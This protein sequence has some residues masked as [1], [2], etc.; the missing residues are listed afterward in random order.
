MKDEWVIDGYNLLHW[1]KNSRPASQ[2]SREKL[3]QMLANFAS[4]AGARVSVVF[5]GKG[6]NDEFRAFESDRMKVCYSQ[7]VSA[8]TFIEKYVYD[9]IAKAKISVVTQDTAIARIARGKGA[10]VMK[11][12]DF[13]AELKENRGDAENILWEK[14]ADQ[15]GFNRP[16]D[17]KLKDLP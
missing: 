14:K 2:F 5:D 10:L 11:P 9:N 8:D 15:H 1:L 6:G 7:S 12:E 3:L 16:F 4:I 13:V 17:K